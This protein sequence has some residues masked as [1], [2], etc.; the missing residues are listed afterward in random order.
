M[1]LLLEH[2]YAADAEPV[3]GV[4]G[5]R[6]LAGVR[7]WVGST[8]DP[9]ETYEWGWSEVRRIWGEMEALADQIAPGASGAL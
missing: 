6:Y 9:E 5:E 4:G 8:L 1:R 2:S 7:R 3:D